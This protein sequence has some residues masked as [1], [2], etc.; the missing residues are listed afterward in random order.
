MIMA[1]QKSIQLDSL[2]SLHRE[3]VTSTS[4]DGGGLCRKCQ[5][6][7]VAAKAENS[8]VFDLL[9]RGTKERMFIK[10]DAVKNTR[11]PR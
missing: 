5:G 9:H 11:G 6:R 3:I 4:L 1:N 7:S 10:I 2:T 8:L